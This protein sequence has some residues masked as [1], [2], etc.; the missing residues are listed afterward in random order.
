VTPKTIRENGGVAVASLT[1]ATRAAR[2]AF[3]VRHDSAANHLR[4]NL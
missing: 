4:P 1:A 2:H 3:R